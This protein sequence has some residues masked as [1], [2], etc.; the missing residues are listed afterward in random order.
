MPNIDRLLQLADHLE[1]GKLGHKIFD[2]EHYNVTDGIQLTDG[3]CGTRG[4][5]IGECPILWPN[6][7]YFSVSGNPVINSQIGTFQSG[8]I[9]FDIDHLMYSSL[10]EPGDV[11]G[12][13]ATKEEVAANIRG[14][15]AR[16]Q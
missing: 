7:W 5:A 16:Y 8:M 6:D 9:W 3:N 11:L 13:S 2:F 1:H 14:F 12:N 15:C 4:C 10:F